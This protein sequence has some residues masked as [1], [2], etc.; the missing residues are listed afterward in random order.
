M[1]DK[2]PPKPSKEE[3]AA[4]TKPDTPGNPVQGCGDVVVVIDPGHGDRFIDEKGT[5]A[6][7][8]S[9]TVHPKKGTPV[10]IEKDIALEVSKAIRSNLTGKPHVKA[11]FLT[12]EADITTPV[13]RFKW[14]TDFA[15]GHDARVFISIHVNDSPGAKGHIMY[16]YS[17]HPSPANKEKPTPAESAQKAFEAQSLMLSKAITATLK[18]IP[19]NTRSVRGEVSRMGIVRYG[20]TRTAKVAMLVETGFIENDREKLVSSAAAIGKEIA[21][22]IAKYLHENINALCP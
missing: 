18:A 20:A 22:G 14:R 21:E 9:G 16:Y 10:A 19:P 6:K 17:P 3:A 7:P 15:V 8:D 13:P 4:S 1:A 11:V 5:R 2:P 12:R